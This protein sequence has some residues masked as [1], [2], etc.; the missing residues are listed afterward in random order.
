MSLSMSNPMRLPTSEQWGSVVASNRPY[1]QLIFD[2]PTPG[3]ISLGH[4]SHFGLGLFV[5]E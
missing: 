5:P 4:L 2:E 3:P 1:L